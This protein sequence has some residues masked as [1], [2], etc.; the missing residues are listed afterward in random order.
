MLNL[1]L[2]KY[3]LH[4]THHTVPMINTF[5][6]KK[7]KPIITTIKEQKKRTLNCS[8]SK[9]SLRRNDVNSSEKV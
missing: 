8:A 7:K 1:F 5:I 2:K 4:I 6:S 9:C 3:S